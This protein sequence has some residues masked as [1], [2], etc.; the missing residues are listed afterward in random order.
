MARHKIDYGIDL[1]TTNSSIARME[2]GKV[3]IIKN[4]QTQMD[5]TPSAIH[6]TQR[7]QQFIGVRAYHMIG[8][9]KE[10]WKNTFIEFKRN[11]GSDL[12]YYS[13]RMGNYY[14][15]EVLSAE[16]LKAL[17]SFVRDDDKL[18]AA[19]ITV[20]ADFGQVQIDATQKA[21]ELAGFE[22]CELLQEPIAASL[23]YAFEKKKY[24]GCWLVFDLGGGTFD[25]ALVKMN[26]GIIKVIDHAGDNRLGGKDMDDMIIENIIVPHLNKNFAISKITEN[27]ETMSDL[28]RIW[29]LSAE[30]AKRSLST[31]EFALIDKGCPEYPQCKDDNGDLIDTVIRIDR[32]SFETLI[33]RLIDRA[34]KITKDL[35]IRNDL[36]PDDI[37]TV[38]LVGGPTYIPYLRERIKREISQ[39]INVTIDP[40]TVVAKGAAIF[41]STRSIPLLVQKRDPSKVQLI[42]GYPA[43]TVETEVPLGLRIDRANTKGVLSKKVYVEISRSD[44]AWA[45]GR[46]EFENDTI[47]IRLHL[48]ENRT[49]AFTIQLY[50]EIG[51]KVDSEPNSFFILQGIKPGNPTLP[52]DIGISALKKE[53]TELTEETE[54]FSVILSKN[55][56][57][58]ATG[59][60]TYVTPKMLRPGN[61]HDVLKIIVWEGL[62]RTKPTRNRWV[63]QITISGA[64]LPSLLPE[65]SDVEITLKMDESR[66]VVVSAYVPYLDETIE[67]IL[68]PYR[69]PSTFDPQEIE[70]KIANIKMEIENLGSEYFALD[71]LNPEHFEEIEP[72]LEEIE[73]LKSKGVEDYDRYT[74]INNR[75]NELQIKL[76]EAEKNIKWPRLEKKAE[77]E[78]A[79]TNAAVERFGTEDENQ[80]LS[81]LDSKL[82]KA[83]QSKDAKSID[84]MMSEL[85]NLRWSI[86]FRLPDFWIAQ[87]KHKV[88]HFNEI[89]W[90]DRVKARKLISEGNA[91]LEEKGYCEEISKII[92]Q[93]WDLM[94]EEEKLKS[95][96]DIPVDSLY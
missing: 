64:E 38:L 2:N 24:Q 68:P 89:H 72:E 58:P 9:S 35:V 37:E 3:H 14:S 33:E 41:A 78:L 60:K 95:R 94:P 57:L 66:R 69:D 6:Y 80:V 19:V 10:D 39:N 40:I 49:N 65:G 77:E 85:S 5:T 74:K 67:D 50:D 86:W 36:A 17:K 88:D 84:S 47:V 26:E 92:W 76:D 44:Q 15:S 73:E 8:K 45:T 53:L 12:Q 62:A 25:V 4:S 54:S 83:L 18:S 51:N 96:D 22:Y 42:L 46:I 29:K 81:R 70:E 82:Q 16:I 55:Q 63:G 1:G 93:L 71:K 13:D 90:T 34:I 79:T 59:K 31:F 21:A 32:P 20:P 27:R 87:L 30:E 52:H 48:L 61:P 75:L 56:P 11:M 23:A 43:T 91:V 28:K 7:K